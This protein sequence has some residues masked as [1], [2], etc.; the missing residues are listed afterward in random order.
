MFDSMQAVKGLCLIAASVLFAV[1][2]ISP[3]DVLTKLDDPEVLILDVRET[4]EH[5]SGHIPGCWL[6]PWASGVLQER[7]SILPTDK[8]IIV[9]CQ[10]GGRSASAAA[11]LDGKGFSPI[12]NMTGGF[13]SYKSLPD[14]PVETG[15]DTNTPAESTPTPTI[16]PTPTLTSMPTP[17]PTTNPTPTLSPGVFIY[18][19]IDDSTEDLTG[20]TDF[21]SR[22]NR[23]LTI[24]CYRRH[25]RSHRLACL[26]SKRP[27]RSEI[28]GAAQRVEPTPRS[29]GIKT[30]QA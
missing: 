21:D 7:W 6:L 18:D 9:Y 1:T 8:Q 14:A 12:Y 29:N 16:T 28:L 4:S 11:F 26:R 20:K 27:W 17:E 24:H 2:N 10:S 13:Y 19:E 23:N 22:D 30:R 3:S 5:V 25:H 15:A